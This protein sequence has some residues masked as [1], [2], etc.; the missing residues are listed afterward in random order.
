M[1]I[2]VPEMSSGTVQKEAEDVSP[3]IQAEAIA[4]GRAAPLSFRNW[5]YRHASRRNFSVRNLNLDIRAGERVLLL[6]ASGIGKSTIL[7]GAAGLLGVDAV[8][9]APADSSQSNEPSNEP[10]NAPSHASITQLVDSDGGTTE[11][12]IFVG[13]QPGYD[14]IGRVGLVLHDPD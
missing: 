2:H 13:G 14:A 12:S 6:G 5:G 11:G 3:S 7:E 9:A 1:Q 8:E 4:A 10:S